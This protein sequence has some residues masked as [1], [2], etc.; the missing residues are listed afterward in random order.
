MSVPG[1]GQHEA[2]QSRQQIEEIQ[3]EI[4]DGIRL[5]DRR[6][7]EWRGRVVVFMG[8]TGAGKT[9]L[10][11]VI[12]GSAL[13]GEFDPTM[14]A[15][16]IDVRGDP[17]ANRLPEALIGH[18][19]TSKT[20]VPNKLTLEREGGGEAVTYADCPG[21]YDTG[22]P[23]VQIRN[24]ILI[25]KLFESAAAVKIV[26]IIKAADLVGRADHFQG[27]ADGIRDLFVGRMRDVIP[28]MSLV[29]SAGDPAFTVEQAQNNL[30][31]MKKEV[32]ALAEY[33]SLLTHLIGHVAVFPS[34]VETYQ[35]LNVTSVRAAVLRNLDASRWAQGVGVA[36]Y[37]PPATEIV[38][39]D[40][41]RDLKSFIDG[42]ICDFL[43]LFRVCIE[44]FI[45]THL[46]GAPQGARRGL[47]D[48]EKDQIKKQL[49]EALEKT[50]KI[51]HDGAFQRL[52]SEKDLEEIV[53]VCSDIAVRWGW[54]L[55]QANMRPILQKLPSLLYLERF[56]PEVIG[57]SVRMI[58]GFV[59]E[60][61][62]CRPPMKMA[63]LELEMLSAHERAARE[64]EI[65]ASTDKANESFKR[66]VEAMNANIAALQKENEKIRRE[67]NGA[68]R[69]GGGG[70]GRRCVI[71]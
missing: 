6:W 26:F 58:Q 10:L 39:A 11:H 35:A 69:G 59:R 36:A 29:V 48:D 5:F 62:A 68:R 43:G 41:H 66:Q 14:G 57:D 12:A 40:T 25:Q 70:G 8:P 56:L 67:I 22:G 44:D 71:S 27:L 20:A 28:C 47:T 64:A 18:A 38:L 46:A 7:G 1:V 19:K 4:D 60:V 61:V 52:W 31:A 34:F 15:K 23:A 16:K 33:A 51:L 42:K 50:E 13:Y 32:P 65:K 3:R 53:S 37:V 63:L 30:D 9:T 17:G 24:A 21:L 49:R 2:E 55:S 54:D 45:A